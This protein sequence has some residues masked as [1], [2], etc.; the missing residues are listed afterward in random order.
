MSLDHAAEAWFPLS[1]SQ[2]ARWFLYHFAPEG[3]GSHNNVFCVGLRGEVDPAMLSR[4]LDRL[5]E[6]HPMLRVQIRALDGRVPE[7]R[8]L[9]NVRVPFIEHDAIGLDDLVLRERIGKD[10][11]APFESAQSPLI[12]AG[13]YRRHEREAV[14]LLVL[15]HLI[16]DGWS[17]WLLLDELSALMRGDTDLPEPQA[18]ARCY[19]DYVA[20]QQDWLEGAQAEKQFQYWNGVFGGE[21]SLL[22]LPIDRPRSL[23]STGAQG[24]VS[25]DIA[26]GML[27]GLHTRAKENA[28][29]L[30]TTLLTAFQILLHRYSGQ[31]DIAVGSPMPGRTDERWSQIAGDF[32]NMVTLRA[33]F[34]ADPSVAEAMRQVRNIALRGMA[35][36]DYPFARVVDRLHAPQALGEHPFFQATFVFQN[37]RNSVAMRDLWRT[38]SCSTVGHWGAI[39]LVP[40]SI[41]AKVATDRVPLTL[42]VLEFSDSLRCD[43][44]YDADLFDT[45]T[46]ERMVDSFRLLLQGMTDD[47]SAPIS[48]LPMLSDEARSRVLTGFNDTGLDYARDVLL[49]QSFENQVRRQP[50]AIALR[51][52][53]L[54][55]SYAQLNRRANRIAHQLI[56]LG[57]RPDDRVGVCMT[58]G[59]AMVAGVLGILKAGGAYVPLDPK[60][61]SDRLAYMLADSEP[62]ALLTQSSLHVLPESDVP[63]LYLDHE[64]T[65]GHQEEGDPSP[66]GLRSEHLAY[67]IYTSGSTGQPK[68]VAIEH[69]N[70]ANFI[71]WATANFGR[72]ELDNTL[73]ATSINFDL[74]VYEI[75]A[76]LAAGATITIVAD[77]LAADRNT[78]VSLINTVPSGIQALVQAGGVS[79]SVR[80]INL[81]GEPLKRA[82]VERIFA[83]TGVASVANLYG[84]T[85]TTTYSTWVRMPR[86]RSFVAHI[87]RPI[88]NTQVYVLDKHLQPVPVGVVGEL[89]IAGEG[90]AR[91]YLNRDELTAERFLSDPFAA[92]SGARMYKTGDLGRW[93]SDGNIE[94][95]GRND[96]Q[97]KIRGFRI[98]LGEIEARLA[99]CS[100]VAEAVVV[101]RESA[102]GDQ[103]LVAYVVPKP[104]VALSIAGLREALAKTLAEYMVPSAFVILE[105][106]PLTPN[107]KLDR[108]ALPA[109]DD[110]AVIA[111]EY[112]APENEIERAISTIWQELLG[113]KRVGRNDHFFELGGNSLI[114]LQLVSRLRQ[115]CGVEISLR[116]LFARPIVAALA[117][118]VQMGQRLDDVPLAARDRDGPL[119]LSFAQRRLWFLDQLDHAAGAAYH[120]PAAMHIQGALDRQALRAT[121]DRIVARHEVLRTCFVSERGEPVQVVAPHAEF[122]LSEHDLR[123]LEPGARAIA[124]AELS[125]TE[126]AAPFDLATGPLIRGRLLQLDADDHILLITKHHIISDGWSVGVLLREFSALYAAFSQQ[127][128][129]PLPPLAVQYADYAGWQRERLQGDFAQTQIEFWR[130]HLT[131]APAL[132]ELPTDR[133][134]P[135]VQS[136]SGACLPVEIPGELV[137]ELRA[138]SQRHQTTLFMT[139]LAG[140]SVTLARLSGQDEVVVGTPV[141][142]R[143]RPEIESL[144]GLFVNTLAI[145]THVPADQTVREL[146]AKTRATVLEAFDHQELPFEQVV[147][148]VQPT[149]S[150]GHSPL[151][152]TLL[153][154]DNTPNSD[155]LALPGLAMSPLPVPQDST[156]YDIALSLRDTGN[157]LGGELEYATD[158]FD[159]ATVERYFGH[160]LTMLEGMVANEACRLGELALMTGEQREEVLSGF[161]P[162][163]SGE[164]PEQLVHRRFEQQVATRPYAVAVIAE[165]ESATYAELNCRANQIA[166]RL[167]ELGVKPEDRVAI[168]V[169]R[170][171]GLIAAA[172]GVLKAGAAYVP[173]DPSYPPERLAYMLSD[174]R[175]AALVTTTGSNLLGTAA[176]KLPPVVLLQDVELLTQPDGN[177]EP[178][179]I[180]LRPD[181]L[182][183]VIYT[184]GS[185]GMPK[186]VM[187]EHA[188]IAQ[189]VENHIA[190]CGL[191]PG[192]RMLQ[193]ASFSFDS[194]VVEIFPTL[195]A[196][197]TL[198]LRPV[199]L[200]APDQAFAEFITAHRI[201]IAD[202]PTAFLHLWAQ[203]VSEGRSLPGDSLRLVVVGG[204]ALERRH[205]ATWLE[206]PRGRS[207]PVLNT[208]GPTEAAVY[209]TAALFDDANRLGPGELSI[210]RPVPNSRVYLL[211][212]AGQPVPPGITGEICIAGAQVARGYFMRPDL[213]AERFA[214]DPF[215]VPASRIYRTGDLGRWRLDGTIEYQGR[216][217]F[218]V[219]IRGFRIELG[220]IEARLADCDGVK[221]AV[222]LARADAMGE[223]RLVAYVVPHP[224]VEISAPVLRD[225]LAE[226]LTDFMIPGAFVSLPAMPLTPNGK[227]DRKALPEPD[228][229]ALSLREYVAPVGEYEE[230]MARVWQELL[231]LERVG[232]NDHFFEVGGNSL[233]ITRLSFAVKEHF[234]VVANV[235]QLY[236]RP[237]LRE[238][239]A[240][241]EEQAERSAAETTVVLEF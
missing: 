134:R 8:V 233:A 49:H 188:N 158:L 59:A 127:Q 99:G 219:K 241:L 95:L 93:R 117:E 118:L 161:N 149:R 83:E 21:T 190:Q 122:H 159:Q 231:G 2:H 63:A 90:V 35:N 53:D 220:E 46:I 19:R 215:H 196:G 216:N 68:G 212:K 61:P 228:M 89:Y 87:G 103:R 25:V 139:L 15:D 186:G 51:D 223:K 18:D 169:E 101:A 108:K 62:K 100:G 194:S 185:T 31:T 57:V 205:L 150:L 106:L 234:G 232:R 180:G 29:T 41:P 81:A 217:D 199:Q 30:F 77:V 70:A 221:E 135:P 130:S 211:D 23:E 45:A 85:E 28:G 84:P 36:Q 43:F 157:T 1:A 240:F 152:Q 92:A 110:S 131:G 203:E 86:E 136:Y 34:S 162:P 146:L 7:Q 229:S 75:F 175:P 38:G 52:G 72:E 17:Y 94:Y 4:A 58:R 39:E 10:A 115:V 91:G 73:F 222:V 123:G 208:Y 210:G 224:G 170:G 33:D 230:R 160:F 156:R 141:A 227:I 164:L 191:E 20:W 147:D 96:F 98:E 78:L 88:A 111:R 60:Y 97:V 167:L 201:T 71:A 64:S 132:L 55:L 112:A 202:L 155:A 143:L 166:H 168:S 204:E 193:F 183:Q 176:H 11:W 12:R 218:Q 225:A 137:R 165:D 56:A 178:Q 133:P 236:G 187:V 189:L 102:A 177:P 226:T 181:H 145:R 114:A 120:M 172:L 138:L 40:F 235:S 104:G 79:E 121:L 198:V 151:C 14:L 213:T 32:V 128:D 69:R 16:C 124:I 54:V 82:L 129:D 76:P 109:P 67:V 184:S 239:A 140:W 47:V 153:T 174:S 173:L 24:V 154:L 171:I 200:V 179:A 50:D 206:T 80:T 26:H 214:S 182:A 65:W 66:V 237:S 126:A 148:A 125:A 209:A 22:S 42:Q 113:L 238:M 195:A 74:A 105:A 3:R 107:G 9:D 116:D 192:D 27:A 144:I 13:L 207:I 163:A 119:E 37:A 5:A 44:H 142:N 48:R 6:R 197:A